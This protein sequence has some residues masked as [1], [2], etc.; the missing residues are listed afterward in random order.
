MTRMTT[1]DTLRDFLGPDRDRFAV[2]QLIDALKGAGRQGLNIPETI[3]RSSLQ[4][5]EFVGALGL[6][7]REGIVESFADR[8]I[9]RLRLKSL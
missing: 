9:Q 2:T 7:S 5:T 3:Q 4:M 8:N 6:A 1:V